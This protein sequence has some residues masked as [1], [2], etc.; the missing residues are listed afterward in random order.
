[1]AV[2]AHLVRNELHEPVVR[3]ELSRAEDIEQQLNES[4]STRNSKHTAPCY[5]VPSLTA[6]T[7]RP[8]YLDFVIEEL[9]QHGQQ[10]L[11]VLYVSDWRQRKELSNLPTIYGQCLLRIIRHLGLEVGISRELREHRESALRMAHVVQ[12]RLPAGL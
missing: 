10:P 6:A 7:L 4:R 8:A 3:K 12:T 1:M 2:S 5:D 11:D 9:R